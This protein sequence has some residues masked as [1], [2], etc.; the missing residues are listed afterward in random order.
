MAAAVKEQEEK[1]PNGTPGSR[2][3]LEAGCWCPILDNAYG[4]GMPWPRDDNLD[5]EKH[6]SFWIAEGCPVHTQ[7]TGTV[8][9]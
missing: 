4:R 2:Q 7:D 1:Y 6:P 8:A 9:T 5:P 3:A